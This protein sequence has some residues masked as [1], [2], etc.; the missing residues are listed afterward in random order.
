MIKG[1][2]CDIVNIERIKPN[3]EFIERFAARILGNKELSEFKQQSFFD[4]RQ[5]ACSLAKYYAGK[6]AFAKALGTG[7][8]D[9][10]FLQDI[11]IVH[12]MYGKPELKIFGR[13]KEFLNK[14]APNS[15]LHISLSDDFPFAQAIVII[16]N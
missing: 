10:I 14:F 12:D 16:E 8:R 5:Q 1:I 11:Q 13:T 3:A 2:G 6:E 9:G 4:L 15:N 7:F